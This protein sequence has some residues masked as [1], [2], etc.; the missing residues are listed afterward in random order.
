MRRAVLS[1]KNLVQPLF[2]HDGAANQ[3]ISS[4]PGQTRHTFD[5]VLKEVE[6]ARDAGLWG[7]AL[8][9]KVADNLKS[10]HGEEA[11]NPDGLIPRVVREIDQVVGKG[12]L[13]II[14]DVALDPYS[15][16]GQDG[17]VLNGKVDNDATVEALVKQSICQIQAG[18]DV[19]APS[20][21]MDGRVAAIKKAIP[22]AVVMSYA[23]K[24]AS[25]FYGPFRDALGSAPTPGTDKKTYQMN[26]ANAKEALLE[27]HHDVQEGADFLMV[28]PGLPYLDVLA[29]LRPLPLP[30][31]VYHVSGEYAMIKAAV[32]AG[33]VDEEEEVLSTMNAFRRA[34]AELI[35]TYYATQIAENWI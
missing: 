29:S 3:M 24:Y 10:N 7:V 17:I 33:E 23:A 8:F 15:S 4:M 20:D 32:E 1:Q 9:P 28:K 35:L 13:K 16:S 19:V 22:H 30:L 12:G 5:S 18:S 34:G 26:F 11:W 14:T 6:R 25:A 31:A 2:V 27:C 21:M